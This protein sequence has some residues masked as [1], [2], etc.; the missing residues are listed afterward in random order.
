MATLEEVAPDIAPHM[1]MAEAKEL[2]PPKPVAP[3]PYAE[4]TKALIRTAVEHLRWVG[5][6]EVPPTAPAAMRGPGG[7]STVATVTGLDPAFVAKL[8]EQVKAIEAEAAKGDDAFKPGAVVEP[9][10]GELVGGGK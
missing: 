5:K 2:A 3:A 8:W 4:P 9:G 1:T 6:R 10:D 7:L